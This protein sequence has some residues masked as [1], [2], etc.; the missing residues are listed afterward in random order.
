M[1]RCTLLRRCSLRVLTTAIRSR[2]SALCSA[3]WRRWVPILPAALQLIAERAQTLVRASGAAIASADA[4]PDFMVCRASAG[5]DAPPVGARLQ[6][7]SGFSGECVKTGTSAPLRRCR[8][9]YSRGSRELP[10]AWHS[11]HARGSRARRARNRSELSRFSRLRRMRFLIPTEGCLQRLAETVLAAVNRAAR[12]EDLRALGAAPA[13]HRFAP[14]TGKC[15]LCF[16]ARP[17]KENGECGRE[18]VWRHQPAPFASDYSGL[19]RRR[20]LRWFSAITSRL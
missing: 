4:D 13:A 12:S 10:R 6:V 5:P 3:R 11:L 16:R 1:P 17:G 8:G 2:R 9:R 7:G 19:C 20:D 18:N 14:I 15:A